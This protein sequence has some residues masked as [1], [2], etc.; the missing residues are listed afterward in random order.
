MGNDSK[1]DPVPVEMPLEDESFFDRPLFAYG[2]F[3][4]GQLAHSKIADCVRN[5]E[6]DEINREM[7]IRDG[8]PVIKNEFSDSISKGEKIHFLDDRKRDAYKIISDTQL[9]NVYH[10]DTIDIGQETFNILVTEELKGTFLNVDKNGYY[11]DYFDGSKDPFFTSTTNFIRKEL[12]MIDHD[13]DCTI[14]KIQ[15]YYMLLWSAIER[16]CVLKYDVSKSQSGYLSAL[17]HD[18]IFEEALDVVNPKDR[19]EIHAARNAST[20]YFN[21]NRP[22]FIVNYYYTIRSNVAH[23][24]KEPDNN[25]EALVDSLNDMLDIFD[26]IIEKTFDD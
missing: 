15:M 18:E 5:V 10:W 3:Q 20:L 11:Q 13:D 9:G 8:V 7:H 26:Y 2:I 12:E 19:E 1:Y 17:S 6:P 24:G 23:R 22:N 14:F 25:F 21:K 16:Y 4:V